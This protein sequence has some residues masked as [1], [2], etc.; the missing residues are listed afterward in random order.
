M[1]TLKCADLG[2][3]SKTFDLHQKWTYRITE[4][5][6]NQGDAESSRGLMVSPGM[7]RN[8]VCVP[9]SQNFFI[10]QI[11]LPMVKLYA[12]FF[13]S[14]ACRLEQIENN[15]ESWKVQKQAD[16]K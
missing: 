15:L 9:D 6:F 10:G 5:F 4:E 11:V 3:V 16:E 2:H 7:N 14:C 12:A 8:E 1:L 13:P